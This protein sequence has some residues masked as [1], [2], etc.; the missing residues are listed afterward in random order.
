MKG[1]FPYYVLFAVMPVGVVAGGIDRA[2]PNFGLLFNEGNIVELSFGHISPTIEGSDLAL[3]RYPGGAVTGNVGQ[4]L[5]TFGL[6]VKMQL[7]PD[8]SAAVMFGEPYGADLHYSEQKSA[9]F[10][11]TSVTVD[12]ADVTGLSKRPA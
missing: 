12:S 11:G 6:A 9:N 7:S 10:G 3:G 8:W 4:A 2:A 5:N 1:T